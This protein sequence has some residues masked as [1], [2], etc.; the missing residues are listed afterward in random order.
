LGERIHHRK[1][2]WRLELSALGPEDSYSAQN[3]SLGNLE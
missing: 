2:S 1:K 3:I